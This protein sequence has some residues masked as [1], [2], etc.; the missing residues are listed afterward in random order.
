MKQYVINIYRVPGRASA[1]VTTLSPHFR[2]EVEAVLSR[3]SYPLHHK[4]LVRRYFLRLSE[5]TAGGP[6]AENAP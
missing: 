1:P 2:G 6:P 4:E 3:Q 5:G